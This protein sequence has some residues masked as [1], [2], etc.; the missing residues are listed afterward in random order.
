M[1]SA[2]AIPCWATTSILAQQ[3]FRPEIPKTWDTAALATLEVPHPD[4]RC[5]PVAVPFEYY[6][7]V[8]IP[9]L[10]TL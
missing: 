5:S 9:F 2:A 1:K 8:P 3:P 6:Y 10:R 7:R 4:P